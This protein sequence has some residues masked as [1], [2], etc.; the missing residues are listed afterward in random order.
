MTV[1]WADNA[2]TDFNYY[3]LYRQTRIAP[4]VFGA[5]SKIA[6]P[7]V[8]TYL[9]N[10]VTNNVTYRYKVRAVNDSLVESNDSA[11][12]NEVEPANPPPPPPDP[13]PTP[14]AAD[15]NL[16]SAR[17]HF[18][19]NVGVIPSGDAL[20]TVGDQLVAA[21]MYSGLAPTAPTPDISGGDPIEDLDP[22]ASGGS[23]EI[24]GGVGLAGVAIETFDSAAA[25]GNPIEKD[26]A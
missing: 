16:A 22:V 26:D 9:D 15:N 8:S 20:V 17:H 19:L 21:W 12:S 25:T 11:I 10:G 2:E 3:D 1:D 4:G 23:C 13:P 7:I 24:L 6:S 5:W 14:G 18:S